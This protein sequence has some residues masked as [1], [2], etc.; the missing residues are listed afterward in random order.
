MLFSSFFW[1]AA[2]LDLTYG[3]AYSPCLR[4]IFRWFC[5]H[6]SRLWI[7]IHWHNNK[8]PVSSDT[9]LVLSFNTTIIEMI[10]NVNSRKTVCCRFNFVFR[11]QPASAVR[12]TGVVK[13]ST[14]ALFFGPG[15]NCSFA[16]RFALGIFALCIFALFSST[17][18]FV[19]LILAAGSKTSFLRL[20]QHSGH[21]VWGN[22]VVSSLRCTNH[23]LYMVP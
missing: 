11:V 20:S 1:Y 16:T 8:D 4:V 13:W 19:L 2:I 15:C 18:S 14:P 10:A 7:G 21:R 5:D 17:R 12:S 23:R 6:S 9:V 22:P 3:M